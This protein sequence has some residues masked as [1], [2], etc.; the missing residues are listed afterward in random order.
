MP[1]TAPSPRIPG[2]PRNARDDAI[3]QEKEIDPRLM[4]I[5]YDS[6]FAVT[7]RPC[8][9]LNSPRPTSYYMHIVSPS[10]RFE[11]P[12]HARAL[13]RRP[14]AGRKLLW[15]P[16][17]LQSTWT[18]ACSSTLHVPFEATWAAAFDHAG[19]KKGNTRSSSLLESRPRKRP[20]AP[21]RAKRWWTRSNRKGLAA[22]S[23]P[24]S[25][26]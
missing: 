25:C 1:L 17:C 3:H 8:A 20:G 4:Y 6:T 21:E 18:T 2:L 19:Q 12:T 9:S 13:E 22:R 16:A 24:R 23:R 26:L 15:D 7:D 14:D 11:T 5:A 10:I